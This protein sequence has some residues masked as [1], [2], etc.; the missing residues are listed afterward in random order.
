[1][2]RLSWVA[3]I[4]QITDLLLRCVVFVRPQAA[5]QPAKNQRDASELTGSK[6]TS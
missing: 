2:I 6:L 3:R 4:N 5:A 1:M